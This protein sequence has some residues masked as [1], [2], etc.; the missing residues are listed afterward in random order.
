[1]PWC[2]RKKEKPPCSSAWQD[3]PGE[4]VL[5][6]AQIKGAVGLHFELGSC[7]LCLAHH[8][9]ICAPPKPLEV[10]DWQSWRISMRKSLS[11]TVQK[12][13]HSQKGHKTS[14][15]SLCHPIVPSR[16]VP[17]WPFLVSYCPLCIPPEASS[18]LL[19][20][21]GQSGILPTLPLRYWN[22]TNPRWVTDAITRTGNDF[23]QSSRGRLSM[24]SQLLLLRLEDGGGW[25]L[26]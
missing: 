22:S 12:D 1:M 4:P 7:N 19:I 25:R 13:F 15:I 18:R 2:L 9:L 5:W 10:M 17:L 3:L 20:T 23:A 6:D 11:E 26:H 21:V 24:S 14:L 16:D 8:I